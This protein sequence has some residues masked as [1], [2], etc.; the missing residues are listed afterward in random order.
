MLKVSS[1]EFILIKAYIEEQCGIHLEN[2]KE[3]LIE[4]RLS[5]LAVEVG[6]DSFTSFHSK[7]LADSGGKLKARIIDLMTTNETLWFRDE[8]AWVYLMEKAVPELM[9]KAEK[10]EKVRIWSAAAS[11]GQEAYSLLMVLDQEAKARKKP[12]LLDKFEIVGTDISTSALFVALTARYNPMAM[13]RGV[14]KEK[15]QIYFTEDKGSWE[16]DQTLKKKVSFRQFNLQ[17][18]F[19]TLGVFDLIL[20]RYVAIYFSDSFKRQLFSKMAGALKPDSAI[21]LGAT[22]TLRGLSDRFKITYYKNA[23]VNFKKKD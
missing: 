11:T 16:F 10:G 1:Q 13:N 2:G 6:C 12:H 9:D 14:P 3:Y 17:D 5:D 8:S 7:A 20:C 21:L 22:E 4:S 19:A 15:Q 23:V 18:S